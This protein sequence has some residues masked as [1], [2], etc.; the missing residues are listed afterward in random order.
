MGIENII[1]HENYTN[2]LQF[3]G[4][5]FIGALFGP[6]S[7][8]LIY[9]IISIVIYEIVLFWATRKLKKS[10]GLEARILVNLGSLMGW[11]VTRKL[12]NS[13]IF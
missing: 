3:F 6:I 5:F 10:Y 7:M 13:R 8:G 1:C 4:G 12:F 11:I 2:V 9:F